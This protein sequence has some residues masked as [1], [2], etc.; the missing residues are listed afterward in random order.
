[1]GESQCPTCGHIVTGFE[2]AEFEVKQT[3]DEAKDAE[4]VRLR[5]ALKDAQ[6]E[7][8]DMRRGGLSWR[9]ATT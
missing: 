7:I 3:A 9:E 8:R 5:R 6:D 4:I 2:Q 1:M